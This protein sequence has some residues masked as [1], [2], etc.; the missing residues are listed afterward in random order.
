MLQQT[1]RNNSIPQT[2]EYDRGSSISNPMIHPVV[3]QGRVAEAGGFLFCALS[4]PGYV[5]MWL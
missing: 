5:T 1:L 2:L 4:A 3:C